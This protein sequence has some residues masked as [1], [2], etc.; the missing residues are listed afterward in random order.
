MAN[1][2]FTH[3]YFIPLTPQDRAE[4]A[5]EAD[6]MPEAVRAEVLTKGWPELPP[7]HGLAPDDREVIMVKA[8]TLRRI[9]G[10]AN[11]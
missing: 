2:L 10:R 3:C 9:C 11:N 1:E 8:L 7:N 5:K 4:L 6:A